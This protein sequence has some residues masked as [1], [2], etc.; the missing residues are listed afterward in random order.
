MRAPALLYELLVSQ[1]HDSVKEY[2]NDVCKDDLNAQ[3]IFARDLLP[4]ERGMGE[5]RHDHTQA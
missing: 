2:S 4:L 1:Y 5:N 3:H